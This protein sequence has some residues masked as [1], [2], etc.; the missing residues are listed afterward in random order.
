MA[1][2]ASA[3]S[4]VVRRRL[5]QMQRAIA[6]GRDMVCEGRDQGTLVF[7]DALCKF[8]LVA[9]P[10]ERARRRQREM[11]A[12]GEMIELEQILREQQRRDERDAA[13]D[14]APMKPAGDAVVLDSTRLEPEQVVATMEKEVRR[15]LSQRT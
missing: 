9:D 11:Q 12:R 1:T 8:F 13:R 15:R 5:V 3:D 7:P 4:P 6:A 10:L 2:E 14:L